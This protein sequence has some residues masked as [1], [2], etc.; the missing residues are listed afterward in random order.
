[1][2]AFLALLR[3]DLM[4]ASR[5]LPM[6]LV[7]MLTQPILVMLVFGNILPRLQ[8]VSDDFRGVLL[9]GLMAITMMMAGVQGVLMPLSSDL[10]GTREVDERILAPIS[11]FGVAFEK[12]VAGARRL[13]SAATAPPA[14]T[15]RARAGAC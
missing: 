7:S 4:I 13:R 11:V 15:R 14:R 8:L 1:V 10:S 2:T 6:L 3:R 5:N 12:V 9:P